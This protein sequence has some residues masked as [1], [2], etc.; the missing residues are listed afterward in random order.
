M[1]GQ[2]LCAL[3]C[4]SSM[5]VLAGCQNPYA[6]DIRKIDYNAAQAR[7]VIQITDA[8]L[9]SREALINERRDEIEYLD[10]LLEQSESQTFAPQIIRE[11]ETITALSA[12]LGLAFNPTSAA[13]FRQ[14]SSVSSTQQE[15]N[16]LRLQLQLESLMRDAELFRESLASRTSPA[17]DIPA[18]TGGET[19]LAA[20]NQTP[21]ST[22]ALMTSVNALITRL[23]G[24]LAA[25]DPLARTN[26][27]A[28][29]DPS[30]LFLDRAAYR[31]LIKSA[32]SAE[33]LDDLHDKNGN[34]LMRFH[35]GATVLPPNDRNMDTLGILR[36]EVEK[37]II[38]DNEIYSLYR[39]WLTFVNQNYNITQQVVS[40]RVDGTPDTAFS[41]RDDFLPHPKFY[42]LGK[43]GSLFT[44]L[45]LEIPRT[46][47]DTEKCF[48]FV[49]G[50]RNSS[51]TCITLHVA[52]PIYSAD[53]IP[54]D[55][56]ATTVSNLLGQPDV[57][58]STLQNAENTGSGKLPD[59]AAQR[60]LGSCANASSL[61]NTQEVALAR[62]VLA[63]EEVFNETF[64][65]LLEKTSSGG[66][67]T[68]QTNYVRRQ[69]IE[70]TSVFSSAESL[71]NIAA[72]G[73][74]EC[75]AE[76]DILAPNLEAPKLFVDAIR[77]IETEAV[78]RIYEV[79]PRERAQ[80]I[81][82]VTRAAEA[83]TFAAAIAG[84]L[85]QAGIGVDAQSAFSRSASGKADARERAPLVI[86]FSEP[87]FY[88]STDQKEESP[89][90]PAFGW[91]LGPRVTVN[92][93]KKR[94]ELEHHTAP[95]EL[96]ADLS[97]PGWWPYVNFKVQTAWAP[98]WRHGD[99][100]TLKTGKPNEELLD[101]EIHVP[102][103]PNNGDMAA[104]TDAIVSKTSGSYAILPPTITSISPS[105]ISACAARTT[106]RI[107]GDNI[108]RSE[109][110]I[111][112]GQE[113]TSSQV[114]VT[115]NMNGVLVDVDSRNLPQGK[116]NVMSGKALIDVS[117]LN[118]DGE[119]RGLILL[120]HLA[121][122]GSCSRP[123]P[124]VTRPVIQSVVL[125]T[126][127]ICDA[128]PSFTIV[129]QN[130][131]GLTEARLGPL[132]GTVTNNTATGAT[133]IVTQP[134]EIRT[135]LAG[136]E[137]TPLFVRNGSGSAQTNISI[138]SPAQACPG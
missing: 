74:E 16:E 93:T 14:N 99:G 101:R 125:N 129:G 4:A 15:I 22:T 91:L 17:A 44:T 19:A 90:E 137:T 116:T 69:M 27:A 85:P 45:A 62:Q 96:T 98:D 11:L 104:L 115:P 6:L 35:F 18:N 28:Q 59:V 24:R 57:F 117:A 5:I 55:V 26:T 66:F 40:P 48:G 78:A 135:R 126:M 46:N 38:S 25:Q 106:I 118:Q 114:R 119:A 20:T 86:S 41:T 80:Q 9:Y 33:R 136:F 133:I 73:L 124:P 8:K 71:V 10:N 37:P 67:S 109:R 94:L 105:E 121:A 77:E 75:S 51:D 130:L 108:W 134:T 82:T 110:V 56:F 76:G 39:T 72:D 58:E 61:Y 13:N 21:P 70:M 12:S 43:T 53:I 87:R 127:S 83:V 52:A 102:L 107:Q 3:L 42:Y 112:G 54:P 111:V 7:G 79:S 60:V 68:D 128:N 50:V 23:E 122:D 95:Y 65:V 63:V 29:V 92:P 34:A 47:A 1:T 123:A 81:S 31:D 113:F 49:E 88:P 89:S 30:D 2:K 100:T 103:I 132:A 84:Q 131:T 138:R 97:L 36:M 32:M 120:H 64:R